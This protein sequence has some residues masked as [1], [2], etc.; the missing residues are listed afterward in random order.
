VSPEELEKLLS[1]PKVEL[2]DLFKPLDRPNVSEV[3]LEDAYSPMPGVVLTRVDYALKCADCGARMQIVA[4]PK[5]KRPFYGCSRFPE[6][7]GT[8]GAHKDGSPL[9][10]PINAAGRETRKR[11]HEVFDQIWKEKVLTRQDA[12][13]WMQE[14]MGL[15]SENAHIAKLTAEQCE[16][17]ILLVHR[18]FPSTQTVI[19][20][21]CY[22]EDFDSDDSADF[23]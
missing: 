22:S 4:S 21:I 7:R 5:F 9:G 18:R 11:A 23:F 20:Q 8:I 2:E 17:L 15:S 10:I 1:P 16:K 14:A 3:N 12:Y 6:C 19:S 13:R